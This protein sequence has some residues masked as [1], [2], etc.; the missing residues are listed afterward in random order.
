MAMD[1]IAGTTYHEVRFDT[2]GLASGVYLY[3]QQAGDFVH[4]RKLLLLR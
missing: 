4:T 3:K 1:K 2:T